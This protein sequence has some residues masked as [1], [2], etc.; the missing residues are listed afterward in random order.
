MLQVSEGLI[1]F[2]RL[3]ATTQSLAQ[4]VQR[5]HEVSLLQIDLPHGSLLTN[6][7]C[8]RYMPNLLMTSSRREYH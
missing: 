6:P 4:L 8:V 7:L 3:P 2:P 5:A 1:Y